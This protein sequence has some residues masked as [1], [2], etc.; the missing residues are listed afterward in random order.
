MWYLGFVKYNH[1][2]Q[3]FAEPLEQKQ[4][5]MCINSHISGRIPSLWLQHLDIPLHCLAFCVEWLEWDRQNVSETYVWPE[6]GCMLVIWWQVCKQIMALS[7]QHNFPRLCPSSFL[8]FLLVYY[9]YFP[10]I[11][12]CWEAVLRW[13]RVLNKDS[14][15]T[16]RENLVSWLVRYKALRRCYDY[17]LMC[18]LEEWRVPELSW[19]NN[20]RK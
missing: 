18:E 19:K 16:Y 12:H 13:N 14:E 15:E 2:R 10:D 6:Y 7:A 5:K 9:Q 8:L 17:L 3:Q 11:C 4:K 20:I 1:L